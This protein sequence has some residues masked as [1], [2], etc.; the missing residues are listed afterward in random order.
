MLLA[1]GRHDGKRFLSP[2]SVGVMQTRHAERHV[3]AASHAIAHW[4]EGYGLGLMLGRYRGARLVQHGGTLQSFDNYFH[5]FPD[6]GR[7]GAG[8]VLLTNYGDDAAAGEL[9]FALGDALL[10]LPASRP[11]DR[12]VLL[13]PLNMGFHTEEW[14]QYEG[15]YLSAA[16]ASSPG[17]ACTVPACCWTS[18]SGRE[19]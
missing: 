19:C 9:A 3:A 11:E 10:G 17:C 1:G 12:T 15:T 5:L 13:A 8:F 4:T 16:R 14:P 2:E 18:R 6:V 7:G